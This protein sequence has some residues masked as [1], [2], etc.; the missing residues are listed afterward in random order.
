MPRR[1]VEKE[2]DADVS[3][4]T[5]PKPELLDVL[6]EY[7]RGVLSDPNKSD[8]QKLSAAQLGVKLADIRHSIKGDENE[9]FFPN[10]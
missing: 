2:P 10:G 3:R 4:E 7:V 8:R 5:L 6:D 1:K 9:K